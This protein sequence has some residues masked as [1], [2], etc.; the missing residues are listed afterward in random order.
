M[1]I[2]I[3]TLIQWLVLCQAAD[4][5]SLKYHRTNQPVFHPSHDDDDHQHHCD[6]D[7]DDD[8]G[9]DDDDYDDDDDDDHDDVNDYY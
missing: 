8:D 3:G 9:D 2:N 7:D 5:Y 4:Y 6:Y 1:A